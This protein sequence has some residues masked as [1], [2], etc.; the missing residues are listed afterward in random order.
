MLIR[1][2]WE[3]NGDDSI[4]YADNF[5]GAF[6]RGRSLAEAVGKMAAET[7]SYLRWRGEAVPGAME[8]VL[9]QEKGSDL[10]VSDAI[11]T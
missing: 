11:R 8:P 2:V 4:L 10:T 7:A 6:T 9:V 5:P 3:H 1:C